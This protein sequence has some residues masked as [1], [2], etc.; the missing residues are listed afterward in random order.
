MRVMMIAVMDVRLHQG[1]IT[2]GITLGQDVS[3]EQ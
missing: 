3:H 2:G 1:K